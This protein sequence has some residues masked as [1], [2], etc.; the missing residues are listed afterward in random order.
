M[1]DL[2]ERL[3]KLDD[4]MT[5]EIKAFELSAKK[6][7]AYNKPKMEIYCMGISEAYTVIRS[8]MRTSVLPDRVQPGDVLTA[9]IVRKAAQKG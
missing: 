3:V 5:E 8:I 7:K 2:N 9:Y 1:N 4:F 6:A